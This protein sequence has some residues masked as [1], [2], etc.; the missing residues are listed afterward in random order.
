MQLLVVGVNYTN[1][2]NCLKGGLYDRFF[3]ICSKT[4]ETINFANVRKREGSI[5]SLFWYVYEH[6]KDTNK[7]YDNP[8]VNVCNL[9]D[10]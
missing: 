5:V 10:R 3:H 7:F 8:W 2:I 6:L 4:L 1:N 9:T